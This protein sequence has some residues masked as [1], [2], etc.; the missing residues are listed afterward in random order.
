MIINNLTNSP[1]I[2]L[3]GRHY[4]KDGYTHLDFSGAYFKVTFV[5]TS[6]KVNYVASNTNDDINRP[7]VAIL[8]DGKLSKIVGLTKKEDT[9]ILFTSDQKEKHTI[10]V[11]KNSE[12]PVS[13][14][15]YKDLIT[16]GEFL[17][18][19]I[20]NKLKIEIFG[21]SVTC[22]YGI[23]A[24]KE[25]DTFKT[26]EENYLKSYAYLLSQKLNADISNVAC[27]GFPINKSPYSEAYKI[28]R[29]PDLFSIAS[30]DINS[31]LDN[32][33]KWDNQKF[34]PDIVIINL[35]A[36]DG[37][38]INEFND[39]NVRQERL[40]AFKNKI[41]E[42]IQLIKNTY[43]LAKI[44]IMSNLIKLDV[45]IDQILDQVA[46]ENN[47]YRF[48]SK[49]YLLDGIRPAGHP[50]EK[51]HIYGEEE[52]EQFIRGNIL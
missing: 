3:M 49:A 21:D 20:R 1:Y 27:G 30:F 39:D 2:F 47:T 50:S 24:K 29:I 8:V 12:C 37:P 42:F 18:S 25:S 14:V 32:A 43:P 9:L 13:H 5:G 28:F 46:N 44:I 15:G 41:E 11:I 22:G 52:L 10:E 19:E 7:Y 40:M 38:Y 4:L 33:P 34:I 48:I 23:D 51:M 45:D 6:L 36:N 26:K 35:G 31:T 17:L 16:D